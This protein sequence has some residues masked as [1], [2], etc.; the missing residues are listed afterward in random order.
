LTNFAHVGDEWRGTYTGPGTA[1]VRIAAIGSQ[2]VGLD[3]IQHFR[4]NANTV[5]FYSDHYFTTVTWDTT[6]PEEAR[7]LIKTLED[8]LK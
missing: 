8:T 1:H 7:A 3:R 2:A 6:G 4:A 5:A